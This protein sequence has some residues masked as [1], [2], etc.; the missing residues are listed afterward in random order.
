MDKTDGTILTLK[1]EGASLRGISKQIGI[2]HVAVKKRLNRLTRAVNQDIEHVGPVKKKVE[3]T[4]AM[5]EALS[6][7]NNILNELKETLTDEFEDIKGV[8]FVTDSGWKIEYVNR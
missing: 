8:S 2:S 7:I 6:D 5:N 3:L 4:P 1:D